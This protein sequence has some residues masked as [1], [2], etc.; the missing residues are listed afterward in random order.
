MNE[1]NTS[2]YTNNMKLC[3]VMLFYLFFMTERRRWALE[4]CLTGFQVVVFCFS[5]VFPFLGP[6]VSTGMYPISVITSLGSEVTGHGA[7][8]PCSVTRRTCS[9]ILFL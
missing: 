5:E 8:A 3:M 6:F 7:C 9:F 2:K 4:V 1:L